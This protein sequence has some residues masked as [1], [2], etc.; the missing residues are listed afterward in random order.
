V[1][2]TAKDQAQPATGRSDGPWGG[3]ESFWIGRAPPF[4]S[5]VS[6]QR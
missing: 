3:P 5:C 2:A 1:E 6:Y 4:S